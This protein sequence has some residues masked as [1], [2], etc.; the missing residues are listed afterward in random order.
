M[1]VLERR[2]ITP[3]SLLA[4]SS[5]ASVIDSIDAGWFTRVK[6]LF[7]VWEPDQWKRDREAHQKIEF[8]IIIPRGRVYH[9]DY[10]LSEISTVSL[11]S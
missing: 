8:Y 5:A 11:A 7:R 10:Y 2:V 3:K 6:R 4:Y 1:F 9:H